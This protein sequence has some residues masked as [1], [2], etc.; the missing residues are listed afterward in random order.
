MVFR[1]F[2]VA[3]IVL[4]IFAIIGYAGD[5]VALGVSA[6]VWLASALLA[7]FV[8]LLFG[9]LV[10]FPVGARAAERR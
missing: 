9:D 8:D 1:L 6:S 3:A 4:V 10:V 2:I 7:F 5:G